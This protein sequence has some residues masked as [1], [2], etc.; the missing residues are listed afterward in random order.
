MPCA[1][2]VRQ[3]ASPCTPMLSVE[4]QPEPDDTDATA[5]AGPT[6]IRPSLLS[7]QQ[8][9]VVSASWKRRSS[10]RYSYHWTDGRYTQPNFVAVD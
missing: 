6:V 7:L 5:G 8:T 2:S 3:P 9:N 10:G 1:M 4:E